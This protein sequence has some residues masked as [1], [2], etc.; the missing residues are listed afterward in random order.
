VQTRLGDFWIP[1][2]GIFMMG[3][4]AFDTFD[5]AAHHALP[6]TPS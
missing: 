6:G 5:P 1:Q 2:R 3:T 4:A